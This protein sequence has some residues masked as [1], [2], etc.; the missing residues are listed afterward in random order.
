MKILLALFIIVSLAADP[1]T[2]ASGI[3]ITKKPGRKDPCDQQV[4]MLIG[5]KMICILKQPLIALDELESVS[6][7]RYDPIFKSNHL[8]L[9]LSPE[10]V[11]T[12]NK[13]VSIL[14]H[15]EFALVLN[16]QV[17]CI[18]KIDESLKSRYLRIGQD[19]DIRSLET[20]HN[21]LKTI[22]F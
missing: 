18:F 1:D 12:I 14:P 22:D 15:T 13:T 16:N 8:D 21:A 11:T 20:V 5:T 9:G 2:P 7:I 19:L 6:D 3:F 10:C 4:K 17:I